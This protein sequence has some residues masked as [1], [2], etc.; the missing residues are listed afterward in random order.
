MGGGTLPKDEIHLLPSVRVAREELR[1]NTRLVLS[2]YVADIL[3]DRRF[4]PPIYH[5]I[6]QR[7]GSADV[8]RWGQESSFEEAEAAARDCIAGRARQEEKVRRSQ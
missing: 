8:I 3:V 4:V 7:L 1:S 2:D 5:W 6:I